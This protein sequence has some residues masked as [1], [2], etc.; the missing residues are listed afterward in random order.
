MAPRVKNTIY[1]INENVYT[2]NIFI[3]YLLLNIKTDDMPIDKKE[4]NIFC[5][6][7]LH[8]KYFCDK[9]AIEQ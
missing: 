9:I 5:A 8:K 2:V 3:D 4:Q 7:Y 6:K 1:S